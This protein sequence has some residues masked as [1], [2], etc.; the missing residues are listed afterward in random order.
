MRS[1]KLR[2]NRLRIFAWLNIALL[3]AALIYGIVASSAAEKYIDKDVFYIAPLLSGGGYYFTLDELEELQVAC[4]LTQ[5]SYMSF[6]SGLIAYDS[7]EVYTKIIYSGGDGFSL[8]N[9]RFRSGGAWANGLNNTVV[10]NDSLAWQLFGSLDAVDKSV[11]V[12][13]KLYNVAGVARQEYVSKDD[14]CAYLPFAPRPLANGQSVEFYCSQ[15]PII[16][17]AISA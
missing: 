14:C 12:A 5:L 11:Y 6:G 2:F 4:P 16:S 1:D 15:R 17:W 10:I 8:N 7:T 13:D 9:I 3:L